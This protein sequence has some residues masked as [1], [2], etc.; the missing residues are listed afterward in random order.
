MRLLLHAAAVAVLSVAMVAPSPAQTGK[1]AKQPPPGPAPRNAAGRVL[2][3]G[4]TPADKGVW[5]PNHVI[6]TPLIPLAQIPFQ[7]WAKAQWDSRQITRMEPHTR[8]K[9]SGSAR[10]FITPYGVEIDEFARL[11]RIYIFD[12]G[13]P[14]TFRTVY[15]DGRSH[16]ANF[17][18]TY[19]GHSIGWWE[20]DTLVIDT[21]GYNTGF[22]PDRM[23]LPHTTRLH[24]VER[25]TRLNA[26][27]M[28]YQIT[29]DDPGAYT[30]PWTASFG[31]HWEKGTELYEY[32]CQDANEAGQLL[33]GEG[34]D[35]P[36]H[37]VS[38]ITP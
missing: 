33:V 36:L 23:G 10:Q 21:V 3:G 15:M 13:G 7:P 4:A 38:R 9:P 2:L 20:G 24:T 26:T 25:L 11:K 31:L 1:K 30:K 22:W 14:H 18:P 32:I 5:V 17:D 27:Q 37:R 6:V 29:F 8:C 35:K 34:G 16:P 19:Y 12:I 28:K